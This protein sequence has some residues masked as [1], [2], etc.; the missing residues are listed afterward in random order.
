MIADLVAA[1]SRPFAI[2][3]M[4]PT[5][6]G[7]TDLAMALCDALP[8]DIIS[9]DSAL[10]Y[11]GMDIGT[12]KP[13]A[14][15]LKRYPH[16]LIDLLDPAQSYSAANFRDDARREMAEITAR[17]RIPLLVGGTMMYFRVLLEG[18][19]ELP[20]A[21]AAVR[22]DIDAIAR[23]HGWAHVHALLAEVD[24]A[25]AARIHPN[26]PQRLQRALEVYRVSGISMSEWRER[27]QL[28]R[29]QVDRKQDDAPSQNLARHYRVI[30]LAVLP[31]N[32][33]WLH[34]RIAQRFIRMFELGFEDEVRQLRA[35]GDLHLELP[36][37]RSVGYRQ[38]WQYLDGAYGEGEC[39]FNDM[40]GKGIAA[41]R[42]LAKRQLT[43]LRG[44]PQLH[45]IFADEPVDGGS[46]PRLPD[47]IVLEALNLLAVSGIS[48]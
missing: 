43:W 14:A 46:V 36:S 12:A 17:G 24:P 47:K 28:D 42:Q 39:A 23:E 26:D 18:I 19:G 11:R 2:F 33:N 15:E 25:S 5:A 3:L 38:V 34:Q 27:E 30:Q 44:W 32:R 37:M 48:R 22:A 29:E 1:D 7:K 40:K 20:V 35:R 4:G 16:R 41:T 10:I 21:D 45:E 9:V 31:R 6:I 13:Q 8:C